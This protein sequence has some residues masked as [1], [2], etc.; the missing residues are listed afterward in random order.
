MAIE[1]ELQR[2]LWDVASDLA[3]AAARC[4][5]PHFRSQTLLAANK[6]AEGFDPVTAADRE[7][8]AAMREVLRA[9]R[10]EDA[11]LGEEWGRTSGT[12]GLTWVLDPID[13]TRAFICGAPTW[14]ILVGLNAGGGPIMGL[15]DQ[16]HIGERFIGGFGRAEMRRAGLAQSMRVRPCAGLRDATLFTTYPEVGSAPERAGFEVVR[17]QVK[18]TRYSLDCYA[19]ALVA[20]GQADLVIEAGLAAY[21]IQGPQGV[22]EAAGGIVTN[23]R[24]QPG[25]RGGQIIAAGDART[26]A[27]ALELLAPFAA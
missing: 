14:G 17:D 18:L 24:G 15:I 19:Y 6:A 21:D 11:I 16:P 9:R 26:H 4:C 1:P 20:M 22:V 27:E 2:E 12:T 25:H 23:W 5:L 3:D 7:A 10:P 13:G 8:E